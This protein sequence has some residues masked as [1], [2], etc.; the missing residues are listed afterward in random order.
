M[1]SIELQ[2]V[3]SGYD[4]ETCWVHARAGIVPGDSDCIVMTMQ[5]LSLSGSDLF[6][7]INEMRSD[8]HG[9]SW[10]GPYEHSETLGKRTGLDGVD[11]LPADFTPKWHAKTEKLLGTGHIACYHDNKIVATPYPRQTVSSVYNFKA[12]EWSR[13]NT[14]DM[15][16]DD[17]FFIFCA[18]STQRWDCDAGTVLLPVYTKG[19]RSERY[20]VTVV[21]CSF[22]GE[23]L[24]YITHGDILGCDEGRGLYEPSIV[25]FEGRYLLTMRNDLHGYI[26]ESFDKLH[27]SK[28][29]QWQFDNGVN[30][31]NYNTQQ[32][33][34]VG[35]GK[36]YLVYTRRC[37]WNDHVF[38]HR[39]PLFMA[40][41][42]VKTLSIKRNTERIVVP[43]RGARL[44]NFQPM[45]VNNNESWVVVAEWMQN[46]NEG[47]GLKGAKYCE[48]FGSD[49]TIWV[50]TLKWL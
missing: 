39:A 46:D 3:R 36:L 28:P 23:V 43:E 11:T 24:S 17:I 6:L 42:D 9:D 25:F 49:N 27:W 13:W 1:Y 15:P 37:A 7:A 31:G 33:W 47:F 34:V 26:S 50:A 41:V 2:A 12:K 32:H 29:K 30:L 5:K 16:E 19:E 38:R 10:H 4:R 21:Q 48:Q 20:K 44:G 40:E 8:D 35:G 18:G 14:F 45:Q 22:N